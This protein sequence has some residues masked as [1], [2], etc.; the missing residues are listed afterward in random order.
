M[1][2]TPVQRDELQHF[3][4]PP[5]EQVCRDPEVGNFPEIGVLVGIDT[6]LEERLD[7]P[8]AKF[9][10]RQADIVDHQEI[11]MGGLGPLIEIG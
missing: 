3:T 6:V 11:D 2:G 8:S 7:L 1:P 5:Y 4:V 9:P 10:W